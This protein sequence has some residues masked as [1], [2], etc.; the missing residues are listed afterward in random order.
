MDKKKVLVVDGH[1]KKSF[2]SHRLPWAR[3]AQEEGYEVHVTALK[4]GSENRVREE[5]FPFHPIAKQDRGQNPLVEI[6]VFVRLCRLLWRLNPDVAHFITLRSILYGSLAA[7]LIGVPAV[8]NSVTGLGFL[9]TDETLVT[10]GLRWGVLKALRVALD[11]Q[12]QRTSFHNPDNAT[13]FV[14]QGIVSEQEVFVTPGS[15][16]DPAQFPSVE[17]KTVGEEGPIVMLATRLLWHKGIRGFVE[18]ARKLREKSIEARFVLVGEADPENPASVSEETVRAWSDA[19][20]V[21]WWGYQDPTAMAPTL[22]QAHVVCLPSYYREGVPKVLIEAASTGRPIVTTDVP[23]CREIVEDGENG[24]L[25]PPQDAEA[26]AERICTL[27]RSPSLRQ[28]MGKKGRQLVRARFTADRVATMIV[29][30]Y[31]QLRIGGP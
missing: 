9:F 23:G 12:N 11:H 2:C 14:S 31:E 6:E 18:A 7:R 1:A 30:A 25:V 5:G 17:E 29:D 27:L 28:E 24:F 26:L 22:Q 3:K 20:L 13:L 4:T 21:E 16:V 8:L 10:R 19:G 15:G